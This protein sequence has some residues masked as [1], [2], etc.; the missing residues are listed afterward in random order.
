MTVTPF[1]PNSIF[2]QGHVLFQKALD[3]SGYHHRETD[4]KTSLWYSPAFSKNVSTNIRHRFLTPVDKEFPIDDKLR[5]YFN[6]STMKIRYGCMNDT[7]QSIDTHKHTDENA[8]NTVDSKACNCLQK[9]TCSFNRKCLQL[10]VINQ[11]CE[12]YFGENLLQSCYKPTN[13]FDI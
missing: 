10:S 8:H 1:I 7:R 11:H 6:R 5:N 12:L 13:P 9:N 4:I 3:K 2:D